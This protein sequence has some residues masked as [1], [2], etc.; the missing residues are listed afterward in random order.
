[1]NLEKIKEPYRS[2]LKSLVELLY[3]RLSDK[4]V[5]VVVY[6]SV[7]RGS[8]RKDSD[9]DILIIAESLPKSRMKR[10]QLFIEVED[11]LEPIIDDIWNRGFYV[12]FSPIILSVEEASKI[13]PIYLDMVE[14]SVILYDKD[15]FF[16]NIIAR[17]RERLKE[18]GSKRIWVKDKW[19]W[20]IKP[21]IKFGE[22]VNIE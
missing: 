14:D 8:T 15:G 20:L 17:L 5:S 4:L 1:M 11:K 18:L 3:A 12:D 19:Y 2:L 16:S 7:A 21:D 13:R 9:V 6:G 10:Q 22:V